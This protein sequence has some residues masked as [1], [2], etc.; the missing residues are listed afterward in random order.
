M[1]VVTLPPVTCSGAAKAG[2]NARPASRVS[3][4]AAP[5]A[6]SPSRSLAMPKSRSF[7]WPSRDTRTF[8]GF[9]SRW[10]TSW[11]CAWATASR[12]SRKSRTRDVDVEAA[13]VAV[14]VDR[15][16]LD[17]ARARGT[18]GR[19]PSTPASIRRAMFGCE[20]R[21]RIEP[22][23]RKRSSPARPR[24]ASDRSFTAAAPFEAAVAPPRQPDRAHAP[25]AERRDQ[26]VG[27]ET[28]RPG[29]SPPT[30][31]ARAARRGSGPSPRRPD[32]AERSLELSGERGIGG[33]QAVELALALPVVELE[34]RGRGAGSA[35]ASARRSRAIP[36]VESAAQEEPRLV[37]LPLGR[38]LGDAAEGARSRR[39]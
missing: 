15:L 6:P 31:R 37:P 36:A 39:R 18:A 24:S 29:A 12:T 3:A 13:G 26:G 22:S 19:P 25:L 30:D 32:L 28:A 34:Q 4:V 35:R 16:A 20:R 33:P 2:V 8:D 27:A 14:P 11:A 1:A 21:A 17:V 9:R 38:A 7:T 10:T 23:R 5:S